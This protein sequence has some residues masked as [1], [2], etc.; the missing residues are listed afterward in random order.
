LQVA[1]SGR[2]GF[3]SRDGKQKDDTIQAT[4]QQGEQDVEKWK[5]VWEEGDRKAGV[6]ASEKQAGIGSE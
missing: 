4:W 6:P 1:W 3:V 5:P 2:P